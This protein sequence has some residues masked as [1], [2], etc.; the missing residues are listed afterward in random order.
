MRKGRTIE[1]TAQQFA[2]AEQDVRAVLPPTPLELSRHL[3]RAYGRPVYLK[4]EVFQ[5]IRTFKIRGAIA[6]FSGLA[7]GGHHGPVVTASAGNHGLA[8]AWCGDRW[9]YPVHVFA[10]VGANPAKLDAIRLWGGEIHQGGVGY[11]Q[12]AVAAQEFAKE[13]GWPFI[14]GFDDP[15]IIAGQGTIGL[16]LAA[17]AEVG[18]VIAGVGGGGLLGGIAASYAEQHVRPRMIG[19]EPAGAASMQAA[20][21]A[22]HPVALAEVNTIADGLAPGQVSERTLRL[23]QTC[24]DQLVV[25][26]DQAL[27]PALTHLTEVEHLVVEPSGAAPLAALMAQPDLGSGAVALIVSGGNIAPTVLAHLLS[28]A[29][30]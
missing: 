15:E 2:R 19:V 27:W 6:R 7:R 10:P 21:K 26:P 13:R 4:L 28:A 17:Q 24:V 18:T 30:R 20:L 8:V 3:S 5:P 12:A 23:F 16:E 25:I 22:G 1:I 11:D 14:H 29:T 9:G